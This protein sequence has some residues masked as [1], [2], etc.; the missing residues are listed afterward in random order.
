MG[1]NNMQIF[2]SGGSPAG[3][4]SSSFEPLFTFEILLLSEGLTGFAFVCE[5]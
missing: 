2:N 5:I 1:K 3:K 4:K